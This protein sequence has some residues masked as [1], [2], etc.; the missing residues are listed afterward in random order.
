MKMI[1]YGS[2]T[3]PFVRR[4]RFIAA[5]SGIRYDLVDTATN[6]GQKEL[7]SKNPIW[8]VPYAEFGDVKV[9]DS[10]VII[11]Y[12]F[13][14]YGDSAI[15]QPRAK[16]KYHESNLLTAADAAVE[17]A[18]NVF[19]LGK[20]GVTASQSAYLQ[21]QTERVKSI[22]TWLKSQLTENYFTDEKKI[23]LAE[24]AL[25]T[26]LDWMRFRNAYPVLEDE[27]LK[28]FLAEHNKNANLAATHPP[29]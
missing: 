18:I 15:R 5:E 3:S 6:E 11:D 26:S 12:I 4:V 13:E 14:K 17:S 22:L 10:H 2:L 19:Y 28:G 8:K 25:F 7:R 27:V 21:K 9:W 23:G 1:L 24:L 16:N 29:T 20:D